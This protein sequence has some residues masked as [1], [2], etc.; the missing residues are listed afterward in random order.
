MNETPNLDNNSGRAILMWLV[1]L[2]GT[3]S[4]P[5]G[6]GAEAASSSASSRDAFVAH[7][8]ATME[9]VPLFDDRVEKVWSTA[10]SEV[11]AETNRTPAA[12]PALHWHINVDH[13]GGEPKYPIGWPRVWR[14]FK[15]DERDW[16][17]FDYLEF[18][19]RADTTR[20]KLPTTP[21]TLQV[22]MDV[23]E[24]NWSR[25]LTELRKGEWIN[26]A[27]PLGE[28]P[29][30]EAVNQIMFSISDS[31]YRHQD[32]VEFTIAD[33]A[34]TRFTAPT[35]IEFVPEQAVLF[36]DAPGL[37]VRFRVSGLK[38]GERAEVVCELKRDGKTISRETIAA[39]RGP[40]RMMMRLGEKPPPG[41]GELV[42][43]IANGPPQISTVRLVESPWTE[44]SE[45][46]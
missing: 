36:T 11:A 28:L 24:G 42:G 10:E 8:G 45:R 33:L 6:L 27:F 9:R 41:A 25:P 15:G 1:T 38:A 35:L 46:R 16:S 19:L 37:P 34:L 32:E 44:R 17:D 39:A 2:L 43:R 7:S 31:N 4:A 26:F 14:A 13:Y 40:Q 20:E 22:R 29:K 23:A 30:P 18:R 3:A 12:T 21:V 5:A